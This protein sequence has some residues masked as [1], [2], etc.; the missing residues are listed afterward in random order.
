MGQD[1]NLK[2]I[3]AHCMCI[4]KGHNETHLKKNC[5]KMMPG[6]VAQACSPGYLEG[7]DRE[8]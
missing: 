2:E 4:L 1:G 3:L 7:E 8:D 5:K 6:L